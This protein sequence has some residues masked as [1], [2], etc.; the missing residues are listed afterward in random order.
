[1]SAWSLGEGL[2]LARHLLGS[3]HLGVRLGG[4]Q[5]PQ[6]SLCLGQASISGSGQGPCSCPHPTQM[7]SA[8]DCLVENLKCLGSGLS[9]LGP[10]PGD[11]R[12]PLCTGVDL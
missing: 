4:S 12:L 8:Q 2:G 7:P 1:M 11:L 9:P 6:G 10:L 5:H 3:K